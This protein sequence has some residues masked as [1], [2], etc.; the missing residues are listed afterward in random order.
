[1][2]FILGGDKIAKIINYNYEEKLRRSDDYRSKYFKINKGLFNRRIYFCPYC[3]KLMLNKN[4]IEVDHIYSIR[5]IQ[6]N[7][8]LMDKFKKIE[9]GVNN[10]GN[11]VA[12]C[13]R[14]NRLKGKKGGIWILLGKWGVYFMPFFR[15]LIILMIIVIMFKILIWW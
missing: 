2:D 8:K 9:N 11:L 15:Y 7:N 13:I 14:C 12:S 10:Q 4:L 5:K 1:M 3:G 6:T